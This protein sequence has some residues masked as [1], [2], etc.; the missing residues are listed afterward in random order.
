M[1]RLVFCFAVFVLLCVLP[2][3]NASAQDAVSVQLD[4]EV[5]S[6]DV[7]PQII[8]G[9]VML[10]VRA[11][12]EAMGMRVDW[13]EST[14][15]AIGV[16]GH[17]RVFFTL[18]SD[19]AWINDLPCTLDAV[20]QL[21]DGRM[22][23]P[24]RF[25]A[26]SLG[27]TVNWYEPTQTVYLET[28][29]SWVV[30]EPMEMS[31]FL[32][33]GALGAYDYNK[34][35]IFQEADR[36]TNIKLTGIGNPNNTD[37]QQEFNIMLTNS[38]LPDI[39]KG[40]RENINKTGVLGAFIPLQDLVK[41]HAPN[42]QAVFDEHPEFVAGSVAS[43]GNLYFIPNLVESKASEGFYIR[44]D[45]LDKLG[46][47]V[48][49]TV[50]EY[51]NVLKAFREQDPNG[52]GIQ[53]EVPYFYRG[54]GIDGLLQ[55][56][57]AYS[58][59]HVNDAGEVVHG[60]TEE[61]YKNAMRE[62]LKWYKEGLIDQEIYSRGSESREWLLGENLG[63][64]THDWFM[65]TGTYNRYSDTIEGFEWVAIA[66]PADVNGVVKETFS[67][68]LLQP[69]GWAISIDNQYPVETIK[70]FDWWFSEEG[71]RA[72]SFG[73]EGVDYT[74]V[75][76]EPQYTEAARSKEDGIDFYMRDIGQ[77][78]FGASLS[79]QAEADKMEPASRQG[80]M[81]YSSH[82]EWY[83]EQLPD[84]DFTE[85]EKQI[86]YYEKGSA[87]SML[88][89]ERQQEWLMGRKHTDATWEQYLAELDAAGYQEV[90]QIYQNAY[91][92]YR[93]A[94]EAVE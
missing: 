21:V 39:V 10:P 14:Q 50:D 75:D 73:I 86:I 85:E 42:I 49:T 54:N 66:P 27:Y 91:D 94:L 43:D 83:G 15:T 89:L 36:K 77:L 67:Q 18:G 84:L 52:N 53:D 74:M 28:P 26:E 47:A 61:A 16:F 38:P 25:A 71:E 80:F 92:R 37:M 33:R 34:M 11:V 2:L 1:K 81:L 8:H 62:L 41:E 70:Y 57:G 40:S 79:L 48:P 68:N 4:G 82:P 20:P 63:G 24:V 13:D 55:L 19:T 17:R 22:L 90:R 12:F 51:Y 60:K 44:K 23:I 29:D 69:F 72:Y 6:F 65:S 59:W 56:F 46:L 88:M 58:S 93:A 87:I 35:T 31:I 7:P 64:S 32:H 45:W 78:E 5:L 76:G 3:G 30:Q 9:R